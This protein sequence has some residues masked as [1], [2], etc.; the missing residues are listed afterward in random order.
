MKKESVFYVVGFVY[1]VGDL[2]IINLLK[3]VGYIVKLIMNQ[4]YFERE[5]V[6]IFKMYR[7]L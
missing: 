4:Y 1:L 6:R 7:K 5:R 2:G 3:K